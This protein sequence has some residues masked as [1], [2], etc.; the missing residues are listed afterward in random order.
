MKSKRKIILIGN[1]PSPNTGGGQAKSFKATVDGL[2]D[3]GFD[4]SLIN[5]IGKK[6]QMN[7]IIRSIDYFKVIFL[8]IKKLFNLDN[9]VV[10]HIVSSSLSGFLRDFVII[11]ISKIFQK[12]III[13]SHNGNYDVFYNKRNLFIKYLIRRMIKKTD[14]IILL[15][16]VL[17]NTFYFE[18]DDSKF[19]Y[20]PNGIPEL[21]S[22]KNNTNLKGQDVNILF[23]SYLI[24][25]KGYLDLLDAIILLKKKHKN[26]NFIF[27]FA[28]DFKMNPSQDKTYSTYNEAKQ[29]FHS[30]IKENN[31]EDAIVYHGV[32]SGLK[33]ANLLKL[34]VVFILPTYFEV[35]AQPITIIEALAYGCTILSTKYRGIPEMLIDGYNGY[36]IEPNSP[37]NIVEV[38]LK[39]NTENLTKF[40]KNS[41]DIYYKSFTKEKYIESIK[42]VV[43]ELA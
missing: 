31:I 16:K 40:S 18:K 39:L 42:Q 38:I 26:Q 25:A 15:S 4:I 3:F 8:L 37:E 1:Y 41:I 28:G 5:T 23:L 20:I 19:R 36:F 43:L 11:G 22:Y 32:V 27:H 9:Y 13:H 33:K 14:R 30:K 24:E 34:A 21:P 10:Y 35:E 12:K 29:L 6:E 17:R 2:K 7:L